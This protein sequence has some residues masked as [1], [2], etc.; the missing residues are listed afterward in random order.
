MA[1]FERLEKQ[2]YSE[3]TRNLEEVKQHLKE[4]ETENAL[5]AGA[6]LKLIAE[7]NS[8]SAQLENIM[9]EYSI[10]E[11][12]FRQQKFKKKFKKCDH[13]AQIEQMKL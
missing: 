1:A 10:K 12:I 7:I 11:E 3:L 9:M 5:Q 13:V 2:R 6:E 4:A 8:K